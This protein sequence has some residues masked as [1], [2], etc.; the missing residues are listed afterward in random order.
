M[1]YNSPYPWPYEQEKTIEKIHHFA[2]SG[3]HVYS[4]GA[5]V[6]HFWKS[7][8][9]INLKLYEER[10][11]KLL[12]LDPDAYVNIVINTTSCGNATSVKS[13]LA[14]NVLDVRALQH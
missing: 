6:P 1:I 13:Q 4:L 7:K 9:E 8:D 14:G 12:R 3:I 10:I 2:S 11:L 5:D